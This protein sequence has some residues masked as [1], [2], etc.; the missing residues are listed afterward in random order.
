MF[1]LFGSY[2]KIPDEKWIVGSLALL[3]TAPLRT[4]DS[5]KDG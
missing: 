4:V 2:L 5:S 3:D 1:I